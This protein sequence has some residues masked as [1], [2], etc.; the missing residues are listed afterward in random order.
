MAKHT[1]TVN[2]DKFTAAIANSARSKLG[3]RGIKGGVE[4]DLT[5]IPDEVK[6]DLLLDAIRN[7]A[8]VGLKSVNQ[9]T[10]TTEECQAAMQARVELLYS[11]AVSAPGQAR[12]AP[13]RDP[14]IAAAKLS[15]KRAI[16]E[17]S[18]EKLDAKVL[19]KT[20]S[21]IFK[22]HAKWV[23]AGRPDDVKGVNGLK[24]VD[25]AIEQA[26]AALE[27]QRQMADSM[28]GLAATVQKLSAEAKA[29]KAAE[30]VVEP[31]AEAPKPKAKGKAR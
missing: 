10:A 19:T 14:V 28:A 31:E 16:S 23:K 6:T 29:R 27:A 30:A 15:I 24:M 9:D 5:K 13:T 17:R 12:K 20:V 7:Y 2:F 1:I 22:N 11:G 3:K 26:R 4:I 8:Q 21:E 25:N 18:E